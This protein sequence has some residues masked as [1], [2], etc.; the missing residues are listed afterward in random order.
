MM[1]VVV[2]VVVY[3]KYTVKRISSRGVVMS[4]YFFVSTLYRI[5]FHLFIYLFVL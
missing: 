3:A 4:T 5:L 2:V 1:V